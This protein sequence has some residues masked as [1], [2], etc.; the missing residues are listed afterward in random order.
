MPSA[1]RPWP[2]PGYEGNCSTVDSAKRPTAYAISSAIAMAA[3]IR[4]SDATTRGSTPRRCS[5][6]TRARPSVCGDRRGPSRTVTAGRM[7]RRG[8]PALRT[9]GT[10]TVATATDDRMRSNPAEPRPAE[11]G[12]R[13]LRPR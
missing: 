2:G 4:A 7:G 10:S 6:T 9:G 11:I 3:M 12:P 13:D 1:A 8:D 5:F